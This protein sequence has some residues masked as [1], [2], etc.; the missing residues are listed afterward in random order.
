MSQSKKNPGA[1]GKESAAFENVKNQLAPCG[2]WCG[3]CSVGNGHAR[4][5]SRKTWKTLTDYGVKEWGPKGI[6]YEGLLEGL[7]AL[8]A[9]D[10]CPGCL[11]GGGNLECP[12]RACAR[13]KGVVECVDCGAQKTCSNAHYLEHMRT[14]A[15]KV[16][17]KVKDEKGDRSK[18]LSRWISEREVGPD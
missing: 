8:S 7:S 1:S 10:P 5:L 13:E 11:K 9:M 2:L 4:E 3:S 18:V 17:M 14:G 6:D 16:G 15:R 12:A